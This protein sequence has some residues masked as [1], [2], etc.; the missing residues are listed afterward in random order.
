MEPW[1]NTDKHGYKKEKVKNRKSKAMCHGEPG[2][3][4]TCSFAVFQLLT[5]DSQLPLSFRFLDHRFFA[6]DYDD[7]AI[8]HVVPLA[9]GLEV[10]ANLRALGDRDMAIDNSVADPRVAP[11]ID[12]V[13]QDRVFHLA[14]AVDSHV[15]AEDR[16][17]YSPAGND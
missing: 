2:S 17:A 14:V 1:T 5:V 3:T 4:D 10:V 6:D 16:A 9:V 8:R 12:V 11:D 15:V 13:E 7:P